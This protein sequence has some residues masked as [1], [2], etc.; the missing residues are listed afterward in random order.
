L[1]RASIAVCLAL[2]AGCGVELEHGLEERQANQV[3]SL[4]ETQG[5]SADKVIEEGQGGT[6]K[7]VVSR[8]DAPR[9]FQI[10]DAHDLPRRGQKGLGET[11]AEGGL[12]PG[13]VEER[14]RLAA[15]LSADLERTLEQIPGVTS[16]RVHVALPPED[17]LQSDHG[18]P[19]AS[20]LLKTTGP[21]ATTEGD[22]RRLCAG[23]VHALAPADV[24]VVFADA[25]LAAPEIA[26]DHVGPVKVARGQRATLAAIA[27]S[28][29]AL[30]LVLGVA[31]LV[32][33]LR[34]AR[35]QRKLR[36]L[37]PR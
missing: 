24:S 30:L 15:A 34:I 35:L 3:A 19:T 14:A 6:F 12:L 18:R 28:G 27:A 8:G 2:L 1:R 23:A 17:L 4:L 11:Y 25:R 26:L 31:V 7:I 21:P 32:T 9:A 33:T 5:I 10:L 20:V 16:A 29:L 22:V 13:L 37:Q 36:D